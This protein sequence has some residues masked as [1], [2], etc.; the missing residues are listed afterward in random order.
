MISVV[1]PSFNRA[2]LL[3][4][5]LDAILAQ[6][7]PAAQVIVVDDGSTDGTAGM[8]EARYTGRVEVL[9]V[10][11]GGDLAARNAG[12]ARA[13]GD[14]VAFC[15][16][17]DLWRPGYLAAMEQLWRATPG[18]RV[19]FG[20]FVLVRDD[21]WL[22]ADKFGQAPPGFWAG[23]RPVPDGGVFDAPI[24]DKLLAFQPFFPS[25]MIADRRFLL[26]LGGWD[27]SVG[28]TIGTD[29]ATAL[30]LAEHPP[31]G[32]L[33]APLVGIR[34]HGAN[35]SG[36]VQA[37]NLGDATILEMVLARRRSLAPLAD[38]IRASV[39]RRRVAALEIAFSRSDHAAV[40]AIYALLPRVA[41]GGAV[42]VKASVAALPAPLRAFAAPALLAAGSLRSRISRRSP[43]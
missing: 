33:T 31:I 11:N 6:T 28:R 20:N 14:R 16:S 38:A 23:L 17:D 24:A 10:A 2:A 9:R 12:L 3:P 21:A 25:A 29:F 5:T 4:A 8:L 36:D 35:Y 39:A 13:T 42:G 26:S 43:R 22:E 34:K 27:E 1:V 19:A 40:R 15:D 30:L 32:V 37:M 18:L 41:R 7:R